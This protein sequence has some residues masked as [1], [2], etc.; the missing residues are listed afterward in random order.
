MQNIEVS[1][2]WTPNPKTLKLV[3]NKIIL[4]KGVC[5]SKSLAEALEKSPLAAEILSISGI[6]E[7]MIAKDFITVT[8]D[9][10]E[11]EPALQVTIHL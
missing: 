3:I 11:V 9:D 2:E 1:L 7:V 4:D 6:K 5:K 8:V 10:V